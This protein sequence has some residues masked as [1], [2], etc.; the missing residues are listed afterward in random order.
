[1]PDESVDV[2]VIGAGVSGLAAARELRRA[3]LT[4]T[5]LEARDR[6]GG[7]VYTARDETGA[8]PVELG[9]EFVHGR[10]AELWEIAASAGLSLVETGGTRW[11][12]ID[13]RADEC[14]IGSV[15]DE[16]MDRLGEA[17]DRDVS[18]R[19]F[20]DA[21]EWGKELRFATAYV[22]GFHAA[23]P[24]R[25]SVRY[26]AEAERTEAEIDGDRAFRVFEGYDRVVEWLAADLDESSV[27]LNTAATTIRWEPGRVLVETATR[28]GR[29][30]DVEARFAVVTLP[31]AVLKTS[32]NETGGVRIVPDPP[33]VRGAVERLEVGQVVRISLRFRE[34]FWEHRALVGSGEQGLWNLGFAFA[35]GQPFPVWWTRMPV[36]DSMLTG[37][38]GGPGAERLAGVAE[39]EIVELAIRALAALFEE[40][41]ERLRELVTGTWF[42]DWHADPFARG[43]YSYV[44]VGA[45]DARTDLAEPVDETLFFAGE[46]TTLGR[47]SGTVHGAI[48]SGRRAAGAIVRLR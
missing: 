12:T 1:M 34:R 6:L 45:G 44:P 39:P 43:A 46:A 24:E 36:V 3:G 5:V 14:D 40:R 25:V 21:R 9:A 42:H 38:V 47:E 28:E 29:G 30:P 15:V 41:P 32:P 4:V 27:R 35:P 37:W 2:V 31:L 16:V 17:G 18:F 11:C 19:E 13:G 48:A 33:R 10:P 8:R 23:R 7:R 26:L 20:V 22:E